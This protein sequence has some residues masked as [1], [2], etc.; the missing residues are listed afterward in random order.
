MADAE[1][2]YRAHPRDLPTY[3]QATSDELRRITQ[4][5]S[6]NYSLFDCCSPGTLCLTSCCLPCLAFGKTQSRLR[7]PT[8]QSYESINGDCVI[9][10]FLGLGLSQWIYQTIRRG[11]LR[12]K[13]GIEGSCCGDCCVSMCCGCCAL[14]QEEK[15]AEIRTRPQVTGYQMAPQ[16]AYPQ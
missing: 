7:D 11:E 10:S 1:K 4:N 8:L 15:E 13:Y 6:W 5:T 14:I 12:N 3:D 16:M 9:W 2:V